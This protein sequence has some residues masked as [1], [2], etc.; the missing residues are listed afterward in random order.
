MKFC[1]R[2]WKYPTQL[3]IVMC[4]LYLVS[5]AP[6]RQSIYFNNLQQ[7]R[8]TVETKFILAAKRIYPGDRVM[9]NITTQN[10]E[11]NQIFNAQ[12]NMMGGAGGAMGNQGGG[13]M[14][15]YLVDKKGEIELPI[16]GKLM[17]AGMTPDEVTEF[18]R[19]KVAAFYK[20]PSVQAFLTGRVVVLGDA[21]VQGAVTLMNDRLTIFEAL[22][23]SG[24]IDPTARRDRVWLVRETNGLR[25]YV[26]LNLNDRSIFQSEYYYLRNNDL[27][28]TE[29][30]RLNTF[31]GRNAPA[32][33]LFGVVVSTAALII[34]LIALTQ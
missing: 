21:G 22:S 11:A 18:V 9:V 28:Y 10:Q 12:M 7:G 31:L 3:C 32:R 17:I 27:I 29:P 13:A 1:Y 23:L 34:S 2:I 4:A 20:D 14:M 25:D 8:D 6:A 5:C 24:V 15:G 30:G 33:N 19:L 16:L 26:M